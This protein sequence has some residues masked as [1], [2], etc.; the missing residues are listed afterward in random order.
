MLQTIPGIIAKHEPPPR[1]HMQMVDRVGF[2]LDH[3]LPAIQG[4]GVDTYIETSHLFV[5]FLPS[6]LSV[7]LMPDVLQITRNHRDVA[8]SMWR[9]RSIPGRT[10][11]G[12]I[13]VLSPDFSGWGDYTDYQLCYWHSREVEQRAIGAQ[14]T[15]DMWHSIEFEDLVHGDAFEIV[16]RVLGLPDP[17][18]AAYTGWRDWIV[19]GNPRNYYKHFP[20]G[21]IDAQECEVDRLFNV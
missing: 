8:L 1:F 21:D 10:E 9:R 13:Y 12:R 17:N 7:G 20:E 14:A 15:V 18:W 6:L 19:N 11:R 4:Y 2:W 16:V 5:G 3:K